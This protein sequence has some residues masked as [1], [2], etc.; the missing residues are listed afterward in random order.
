LFTRFGI[1]GTLN[2]DESI[3]AYGGQQLVNGVPPYASIFDPKAPLATLMCGLG[4][5]LAHLFGHNELS[6][7]RAM[8]GLLSVLAVLSIY[9]LALQLWKS[10]AG[11]V[12]AAV[13][14]ASF[15]RF[16][17][18]ALGGPDAKTAAL[19]PIVL[20]ML[21]AARRQWFRAGLFAAICVV[22]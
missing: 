16:A 9:L 20:C 12:V 2:R 18:D 14:F 5:A 1:H 17:A 15:Y 8:F 13:V 11:A 7:I 10:I 21:F 4:A 19:V 3:Y 6:G 22:A